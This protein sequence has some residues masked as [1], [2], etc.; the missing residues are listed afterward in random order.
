[1]SS[2]SLYWK[3][4][5]FTSDNGVL[6]WFCFLNT[7]FGSSIIRFSMV[8]LC[9]NHEKDVPTCCIYCHRQSS[10]YTVSTAQTGNFLSLELVDHEIMR[11]QR[12]QDLKVLFIYFRQSH[13]RQKND[14]QIQLRQVFK[15]HKIHVSNN[16]YL[17][18]LGVGPQRCPKN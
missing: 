2:V 5:V 8:I 12:Y 10:K 18:H 6:Q 1:M 3:A 4:T 13:Y 16:F 9:F 7:M 15:W 14:I 17:C 11:K